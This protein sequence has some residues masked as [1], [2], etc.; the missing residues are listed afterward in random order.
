MNCVRDF[1]YTDYKHWHRILQRL[2]CEQDTSNYGQHALKIFYKIIGETLENQNREESKI[3]LRYFLD[4]FNETFT[5]ANLDLITLR[6][7]VFGYSQMAGPCKKHLLEY[8]VRQMYSNI[9][10]R[11]LSFSFS[12]QSDSSNVENVCYYQEALSQLLC[13]MS[14]VTT[15]KINILVKL[16]IYTIKRFPDL[17]ITNNAFAI[18][19][20]V[21]IIC[22]I[23]SI[24]RNLLQRYLDNIIYD[25]IAWSCS[26]TLALD[27]EL[28]REMGNLQQT[29]I[30]YK[31]YLTL[32]TQ[33]LNTEKYRRYCTVQQV[34]ETLV[35]VCMTL[36]DRL[37]I[38]VK[39]QYED[40]ALS[41][42]ALTQSAVNQTD[43]RV[44][45][46]LIDLYIN[47][48][49][50]SDA[51][52]YTDII[53]DFLRQIIRLSYKYPLISGFYK[54]VRVAL[55]ILDCTTEKEEESEIKKLVSSYLTNIV[56]L[57]PTFSNELLIAS[58]Y[59]I[60]DA[61]GISYVAAAVRSSRLTLAFR[62]AF[63]MGLSDLELAYS[64][65]AA[66]KIWIDSRQSR[67][68]EH[69]DESIRE[70]VPHL[71]LYLRS[72]ESTVEMLQE[73][74]TTKKAR[75]K[76]IGLIDTECTLRNFQ[77]R[78]LLFLGSLDYDVLSSFLHE[79]SLNTGA[80]WDQKNLLSYTLSLPEARLTLDF[81]RMLPRVI[82]LAHDSSDRRTRIAACE[83]LHSMVTLVI[84]STAERLSSQ[85]LFVTLYARLCPALLA[86]GCDSDEVVRDLFQPF[87]LQL[88]HWL[89]SELMLHSSVIPL[90]LDSI[91]DSLCDDTNPSLREFAGVCLGEFTSWSIRQALREQDTQVTQSNV[92][93]VIR[94]IKHFALHPSVRKRVAAAVAFNHLYAIL[95]EDDEIVSTYWLEMFYCFVRSMDGC[96]DPSI[97]NA[98]GHIEKV[99]RAKADVLNVATQ[100]RRK[101]DDFG[102]TTLTHALYWLLSQC[103]VLDEHC[104]TTCK[105]LYVNISQYAVGGSAQETMRTF[106]ETYGIDRLNSI[107]LKDLKSN[108]ESI[109]TINIKNLLKVLD[110]YT[111]LIERQLLPVEVLF[112]TSSDV[113]EHIIFACIRNFSR[114]FLLTIT[115]TTTTKFRELDELQTLQC[116]AVLATLK[117]VQVL[118]NVHDVVDILPESL[119]DESLFTLTIK[120]VMHPHAIG[121][122]DKNIKM[123]DELPHVLETL[124]NTICLRFNDTL[125]NK[126]KECLMSSV[127]QYVPQLLNLHNIA[128]SSSCDEQ[129]QRVNGLMILERCNLFDRSI[130]E[131][132]IL[133][134]RVDMI[135]QIFN[136]LV[137]ERIGE[138]I[139]SDLSAEMFEYLVSLMKLQLLRHEALTTE[140]LV[141]L[142]SNDI[143]IVGIDLTKITHGEYF[144]NKFNNVIFTY[145]LTNV[146]SFTYV[147]NKLSRDNPAFLL[148]LTEDMLL[149][150]K[151]H[152]HALQEYVNDIIDVILRR[153]ACLQ[154]AV[155]GSNVDSHTE[156]LISIY[157]TAVRLMSKPTEIKRNSAYSGLYTW[158]GQQ[159]IEA[160]D[161]EYKTRILRNFLICLTDTTDRVE[162]ICNLSCLYTLKKDRVS[163]FSQLSNMTVI[164]M[165]VVNCFETLLVLLSVTG[166][167]VV[168]DC[169]INFAAG[170]GRSLF[171]NKLKD[172]LRRY[173]G[174]ETPNTAERVLCSLEMTYQKFIRRNV[175]VQEKF[176][177]LQEFL[178]PAFDCCNTSTIDCFFE[179]NICELYAISKNNIV[180]NENV[181]FDIVSKIGCYQ[182]MAIMIT[183]VEESK[184]VDANGAIVTAVPNANLDN[185]GK[186]QG[187][188]KSLFLHAVN[189]RALR[190]SQPKCRENMRL[191]QCSAY[192]FMLAVISLKGEK[193]F[194]SIFGEDH[195]KDLFIWKNIIDCEKCYQLKQ[196]GFLKYPKNREINV[197][198]KSSIDDVGRGGTSS[199]RSLHIHSYDLSSCSLNE[200]LNAYDFNKCVPL[201]DSTVNLQEQNLTMNVIL[202]NDDFNKHECM[203]NIC[204]ILRRFSSLK[205]QASE[206]PK[207]LKFFVESMQ[208]DVVPRNIRLFMLKIINN[209]R[210]DVF[211]P[212]AKFILPRIA[213]AV[214][215]YL[216]TDDLNYI[217]T[218]VLETLIDWQD[219]IND[220]N[221]GGTEVQSLFT[222]LVDKVLVKQQISH[223]GIYNYNL[224]LIHRIVKKWR[225]C[226]TEPV[227]YLTK[228]IESAQETTVDLIVKFLRDNDEMAREIVDKNLTEDIVNL[229][230]KLLGDWN[231]AEK[232]V[233]RYYECLGWYLKLQQED[234]QNGDMETAS[235]KNKIHDVKE[236]IF[237]ILSS[238]PKTTQQLV[239]MEKQLERI[240]VLCRTCPDLAVDY[241]TV[242]TD[243]TS[244]GKNRSYCLEI[245]AMAIPRAC[246]VENIVN[247]LHSI[248]LQSVLINR[249]PFCESKALR[250]VHELVNTTISPADL[251]PYV[252]LTIPF[253]ENNSTEH[254]G[255]VYDVLMS[256]YKKYSMDSDDESVMTLRS[257]SVRNLLTALLDPS[258]ELQARVL[259]FWAEE[260]D[261][262][263]DQPKERLIA[264]LNLRT[265]TNICMNLKEEEAYALL[266]PLLILQLASRSRD[267]TQNMFRALFR[268]CTYEDYEIA[269]SWRRRNLS[270]ITPM[271]VDSLASQIN[272]TLSQ[273]IDNNRDTYDLTSSYHPLH[274]ALRLRTTQDLQFEPTVIDDEAANMDTTATFN[275]SLLDDA[276]DRKTIF[277]RQSQSIMR[278]K[279]FPRFLA[280]SSNVGQEIRQQHIQKNV[281]RQEMIKQ[282]N[283]RQRNSVRLHRRY[284]NGD[285]PDIEI[286]HSSLIEP[287]QQLIKLDGLIRKDIT[288]LLFCSLIKES[289]EIEK[290]DN[291][292]RNVVKNLKQILHDSTKDST[293]NAVIL[294]TLLEL[295]VTDC[296]SCDIV[297]VS[298]TN[299]LNALGVLLLERSLQPDASYSD[300]FL[301][302][303][304][305]KM[306]SNEDDIVIKNWTKIDKWAQ[307]ASLY[308][309]LD[310]VDTVLSIFREQSY[311]K[312]VQEAAI[313]NA[314]SNWMHTRMA[315]ERACE[316]TK[317]VPSMHE[318]CIEGLFEVMNNLCDWSMVNQIMIQTGDLENVWNSSRRDWMIP[319]V[320][321]AY[322]QM[323]GD[324]C[325]EWETSDHDLQVIQSWI[326]DSS[327]LEHIKSLVG[328]NLVILLLQKSLSEAGKAAK[329]SDLFNDLLDKTGEQWVRLNPLCTELGIRKLRKLQVM[330]D[331]DATLKVLRCTNDTDYLDR[332]TTLLDFWTAKAPTPR[333][334][335][336]QWNKLAAYRRYSSTLFEIK[337]NTILENVIEDEYIE[338][339]CE[340]KTRIR[341]VNHHM[342]LGIIDA[343]LKQKH[344][345]VAQKH[346]SYLRKI[347]AD[348]K[349]RKTLLEAKIRYL[350][351]NFEV[352]VFRKMRDYASSW[353]YSHQLLKIYNND[354]DV[355]TS[356]AVREH[357]GA[358]ASTIE[359]LSRENNAFA[360]ALLTA[361][362]EGGEIL[363]DIGAEQSNDL[364]SVKEH[365][366]DYSLE[367]LRSCS[368]NAET[369]TNMVS[370]KVGEYY[371]ALTRH[372]YNW[373]TSDRIMS[374]TEK[375]DIFQDFV[376]ATLRAM[377]HNYH[378]A[379]H[380][381]PYLLRSEWL[382]QNGPAQRTFERECIKPQPWLF[383][384]WRDLLFSHLSTSHHTSIAF[385]VVPIVEKLAE[386]YPDAI[387]YTYLL[388]VEKNPAI[389]R[390]HATRR[391]RELLQNKVTEIQQF[392]SAIQYVAQPELY[393]KYYLNEAMNQLSKGDT[394]AFKSLLSKVYPPISTTARNPQPGSVY[395]VIA[396]YEDIIKKLDP[397]YCDDTRMKVQHIKDSLDK[398]LKNRASKK[399]LKEYSPFLHAYAGGNIEIP[400]QYTGDREPMPRY[401]AKIVKIE[402][403]VEVMPSLRK[404]TR[405]SMIGENGRE[406]K[407][408]VK[409][410]EDLTIDHG[411]QQLYA[412]MNRTLSN[413][414]A[415]R[416]RRL[417]ID[418]YEIIPLSRSFGLIQ[419]I[420]D[421]KSLEELVRFTLSMSEK[422]QHESNIEKYLSWIKA[423]SC[424]T[425][426]SDQYKAAIAKY[427]QADVV[428]Q[429]EK[430]IGA[431][432]KSALRDAF[433]VIS[434]S[435]ESFVTL[436]RN[437][438]TSYATMCAA[439]WIS[440][441]GDRHLQNTL[442]VIGSGRCL[443][444]DFGYAFDSGIRGPVPELVPFRL[445]PQILELLQPFTEKHF[446]STIMTHVMRAL[447]D[448]KGPILTCMD[449]FVHKP[450]N[451]SSIYDE[452]TDTD[453][454]WSF[455][456]N[457]RTV[458]KKLNG[459][460]PSLI[461]LE[462]L[463][464]VHN[465]EH[466]T[467][468]QAIITGNDESIQARAT[469]QN[470]YLTPA[471]Q[472]NCLLD[473]A[474]DLNILGRMYDKWQPWL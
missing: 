321:D 355:D 6:L 450:V 203:P 255:L 453:S 238:P 374:E 72:T 18:S 337:L 111:W 253:L 161:L 260:T 248:E 293:F 133:A 3:V 39:Q 73:L 93:Q 440:G 217:I 196:Q 385:L 229:L 189:V 406:Y 186:I 356:I 126:F 265:K 148:K 211:K 269:V 347:L 171:E 167:I 110:Y 113:Q 242:V 153:F 254:R 363:R 308:K 302:T 352:D 87:T 138:L 80:S 420:E 218:D 263:T 82:T 120:C 423:A 449:I 140:T 185:V 282:E 330:S 220:E 173:Y 116:K 339:I 210:D 106:V 232:D 328:E 246:N 383:L 373:L 395:N 108:V 459:I 178:L 307:L 268:D 251:L 456:R 215:N 22:N 32:W 219:D 377:Y 267:Y 281:E 46:N 30:C 439:H 294:E 96:D 68:D 431:T 158:I 403:I 223:K 405:I 97:I 436:R 10:N 163:L 471:E 67:E 404:P 460:H 66:L 214:T 2:S 342:R 71:E 418:T 123:T 213:Q 145:M 38:R 329:L 393:L 169:L 276:F 366:F 209:M 458:E 320:C 331:V 433:T 121:F 292:R 152:R 367:K 159:L 105:E 389:L 421:T 275:N 31:N 410:G 344:Q 326:D 98:L 118:L 75:L 43:F 432:R 364:V 225:G 83:V 92:H 181:E 362:D 380:Y 17:K 278:C 65:L 376:S 231:A 394:S 323:L 91:F 94:K 114:Q 381:F 157:G 51:S 36:I 274:G 341:Q 446:F 313:A 350:C 64:A 149:H 183:R 62:I 85:N 372:Y 354:G 222:A 409:F 286:P 147:L 270:Y 368:D 311:D 192:N 258:Q 33:L 424:F 139:C 324:R 141:R 23:A 361:N 206:Q 296:D 386:T 336:L 443:G 327:R 128:Q 19:S 119:W 271:F 124:L 422:K 241:I 234:K 388:A 357:I 334:N 250:I 172:H 448:D 280:K 9:T 165:K 467:R 115:T 57:L 273:S 434:P 249:E 84:G 197:N 400:G 322:V 176:D 144:L 412:T 257:E 5:N 74:T 288:V 100:N 452:D 417:I 15:E 466:L 135:Q 345:Y 309:S 306:K 53:S 335:L 266:V 360:E 392:L 411:L 228:K 312:N 333:D 413:D 12:E 353:K 63:S 315:F 474:T 156:R 295:N 26:H 125:A 245:F 48:M 208:K 204:G 419:W 415:C 375:K 470:D 468:Y 256:V 58:L 8:D 303:P 191:L 103:S 455:K 59:L 70:I 201:S 77:R 262:S 102:D 414:T 50:A 168:L 179:R 164:P 428:A 69:M 429:M 7:T 399:R 318:Y 325:E 272:C 34:A 430:L 155:T 451:R 239:Y 457:I 20:L 86:L 369:T 122:D 230:L 89:S 61:P 304:E 300:S 463:K 216:K 143:L 202:E 317:T 290:S 54:L 88:M 469:V 390:D 78:I 314:N 284:R 425:R 184:I 438:V 236:K 462:Q 76:R 332:M 142:I 37:D 301:P 285:F 338:R 343:A 45:T 226:L 56:K 55:K 359:R 465:G 365:L 283:I 291:F 166:S 441:I 187:I 174:R 29:P 261:L 207:F 349:P 107:I 233:L 40:T 319:H 112:P 117:F 401:H 99:M 11:A 445:T 16:S 129:I 277:S 25:G 21:R 402:P 193:S 298:K 47:L 310:D 397:T 44:F 190:I 240:I 396:K 237:N 151:R 358:L 227:V 35:N 299:G 101:P 224:E 287:L 437:F 154:S 195:R 407:F 104:R 42:V 435:P 370:C 160:C 391:I 378:P 131:I 1:V 52:L 461:T 136:F 24:D 170:A 371:Y 472:V 146:E 247:Q 132:S 346:S 150:L 137:C 14:D 109:S 194:D 297:R 199:Q 95:R 177:I 379:T 259:R 90:V 243:I 340:I 427:K 408:L 28:Q 454:K 188:L 464:E 205:K 244:A 305:K 221:V 134:N 447:R 316:S 175:N 162:D 81:D 180:D 384:R 200:D 49:D 348:L 27:V 264:M 60:L 212:Y 13:H 79:R 351:A 252:K 426:I 130:P 4:K 442:V 235:K 387:A 416:Q 127:R 41:D 279:R 182:L 473:Q 289:I 382:W 198:I 444:I 398:S